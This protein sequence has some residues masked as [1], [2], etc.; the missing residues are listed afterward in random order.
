MSYLTIA[1][2][3][4]TIAF[5]DRLPPLPGGRRVPGFLA[6]RAVVAIVFVVCISSPHLGHLTR[7]FPAP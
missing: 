2:D 1:P 4:A 3:E 7:P 6:P 5:H